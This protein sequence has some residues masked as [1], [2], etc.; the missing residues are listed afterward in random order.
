MWCTSF[1]IAAERDS[2]NH[3]IWSAGSKLGSVGIAIRHGVS[4]HGLALNV[5][6]DLEP[7][8]W[9]NPCGLSGVSMTSMQR[10]SREDIDLEAVKAKMVSALQAVFDAENVVSKKGDTAQQKA[11]RRGKT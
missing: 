7:F 3:G 6:L 8:S 1:G 10:E 2:R 5:N 4:Y 11:S 9:I